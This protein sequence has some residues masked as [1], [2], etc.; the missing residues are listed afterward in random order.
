MP[1]L[2][3]HIFEINQNIL[4]HFISMVAT[5]LIATQVTARH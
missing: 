4:T 2:T 1:F 5:L 3:P